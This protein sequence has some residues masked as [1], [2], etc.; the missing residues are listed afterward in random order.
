MFTTLVVKINRPGI[1]SLML[2][3]YIIVLK[4]KL[5]PAKYAKLSFNNEINLT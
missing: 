3:L 2:V 5:D 1:N 4:R